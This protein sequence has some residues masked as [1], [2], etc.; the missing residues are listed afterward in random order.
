[1]HRQSKNLFLV[2]MLAMAGCLL[3]LP[4]CA[5][6]SSDRI[7]NMEESKDTVYNLAYATNNSS[8]SEMYQ[9]VEHELLARITEA[10]DGRI[11]FTEYLA[12]SLVKS[13]EGKESV[14]N[15]IVDVVFDSPSWYGGAFPLTTTTE[16]A[17]GLE[18][19][20]VMSYVYRDLIEEFQPE[21]YKGLKV[22]LPMSSG[23]RLIISTD[24]IKSLEDLQNKQIRASA[25]T[26][27]LVREWGAVPTTISSSDVYEAL[28]NNLI[29]GGVFS[30]ES[31]IESRY[32]DICD[33]ITDLAA[34]QTNT[35]IYMS[36]DKFDAL[37]EDIQQIIEETADEFFEEKASGWWASFR[38]EALRIAKENNPNIEWIELDDEE[39][40][41]WVAA[42]DD[43][44][45]EYAEQLDSL[46]YNGQEILNWIKERYA[47]YKQLYPDSL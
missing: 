24:P 28:Q 10:T 19:G 38:D 23:S 31:M 1:M 45:Q 20:K 21:E 30:Y 39:V 4:G 12:S 47:H 7:K 42:A 32:Y 22:L 35:V 46:G 44:T 6:T 26:S 18:S 14:L 27:K 13:G 11:V 17:L 29:S 15:D 8:T 33:F 36:Q 43:Y 34:T 40:A 37:P 9:N 5:A 3:I 41:R 25:T 2:C 16:L